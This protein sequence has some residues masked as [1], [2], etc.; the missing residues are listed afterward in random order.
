M[1]FLYQT[2][3]WEFV[4]ARPVLPEILKGVLNMETKVYLLS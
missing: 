4:T 2:S 1:K 3:K